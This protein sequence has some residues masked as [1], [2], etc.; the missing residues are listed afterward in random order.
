MHGEPA[1]SG[2]RSRLRSRVSLHGGLTLQDSACE[3]PV[4]EPWAGTQEPPPGNGTVPGSQPRG[5]DSSYSRKDVNS[6]INPRELGGGTVPRW[7]L[8]EDPAGGSLASAS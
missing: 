5:Q 4:Q 1:T 8:G 7:P 3:L 6:F 2:T